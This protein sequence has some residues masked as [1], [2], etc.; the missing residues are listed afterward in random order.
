MIEFNKIHQKLNSITIKK[1]VILATSSMANFLSNTY[2]NQPQNDFNIFDNEYDVINID[3]ADKNKLL[4]EVELH[5]IRDASVII[6][7]YVHEQFTF[8]A[9]EFAD[10]LH[11]RNLEDKSLLPRFEIIYD[12]KLSDNIKRFIYRT[13]PFYLT[14]MMYPYLTVSEDLLLRSV[15]EGAQPII[16]SVSSIEGIKDAFDKVK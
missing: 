14:N 7:Q 5:A 3:I 1:A 9:K 8:F 13:Q 10:G 16:V 15:F 6:V 12:K 4:T 11:L 2:F